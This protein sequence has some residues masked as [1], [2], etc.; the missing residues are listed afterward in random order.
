MRCTQWRLRSP[1]YYSA[2]QHSIGIKL[3]LCKFFFPI[4]SLQLSFVYIIELD[5]TTFSLEK[6]NLILYVTCVAGISEKGQVHISEIFSPACDVGLIVTGSY[7]LESIKKRACASFY[8]FHFQSILTQIYEKNLYFFFGPLLVLL[9]SS[10][11][12]HL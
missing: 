7:V 4:P 11:G 2:A 8:R 10:G 12:S 9:G 1:S 5:L 6:T 3:K